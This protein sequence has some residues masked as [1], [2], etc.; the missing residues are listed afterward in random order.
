MLANGAIEFEANIQHTTIIS[1]N[2]HVLNIILQTFATSVATL[3]TI[4]V[5]WTL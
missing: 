4:S 1:Q 5:I 2:P 3:P